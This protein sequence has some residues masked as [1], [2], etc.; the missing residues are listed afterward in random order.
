[1]AAPLTSGTP[2]RTAASDKRYR[3]SGRS[4]QSTMMLAGASWVRAV[5]GRMGEA[6]GLTMIYGFRL[7]VSY[8]A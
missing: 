7:A 1:M 3:V 4:V 5:C 6:L 2:S 8:Y